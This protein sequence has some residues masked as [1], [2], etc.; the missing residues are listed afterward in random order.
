VLDLEPVI[1]QLREDIADPDV[2]KGLARRL[3]LDN[4]HRVTLVMHPDKELSARRAEAE[5]ARLAQIKAGLAEGDAERII[6]RAAALEQRQLQVDDPDVLPR[7]ERSDIP[8]SLPELDYQ[9]AEAGSLRQT[10]YTQGTN[11]L[12]YQQVISP[13]PALAEEQLQILPLYANILTELGVGGDDYLAT[14]Q[15]HS[16]TVGSLNAFTSIR[17]RVDDAATMTFRGKR[18]P[19]STNHHRQ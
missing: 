12:V 9:E 5:A 6:Q 8:A 3:L 11:G 4:P 18:Q 19:V 17:G 10:R 1:A 14:Q 13:L 7:V 2:I 15:R 16:A